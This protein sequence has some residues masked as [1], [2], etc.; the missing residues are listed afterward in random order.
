MYRYLV[1]VKNTERRFA[2]KMFGNCPPSHIQS[3]LAIITRMYWAENLSRQPADFT[4]SSSATAWFFGF[5][6]KETGWSYEIFDLNRAD[7]D[8]STKIGV[9]DEEY[10]ILELEDWQVGL[11]R[12]ALGR[13]PYKDAAKRAPEGMSGVE[14]MD[15]TLPLFG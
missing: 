12:S 8:G 11:I 5:G 14:A 2:V 4:S 10:P 13:Y 3:W 9:A 1:S 7:K 6:S 15:L